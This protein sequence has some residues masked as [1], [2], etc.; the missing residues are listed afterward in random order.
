MG[1]CFSF[2]AAM[3]W[4]FRRKFRRS[5]L[6]PTTIDLGDGTVM[7]C[8]TPE[9]RDPSKPDLVL[10]HGVGGSAMWEWNSYLPL[11]TPR[12]N[13]YVPDLVFFGNS[14]TTRPERSEQFQ[15]Q[16]VAAMM[17]A[18]GVTRYVRRS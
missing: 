16:S 8:W 6:Q 4:F 7:H 3:D 9:S 11:L 13:V 10:I 12:Y 17:E 18:Q 5:G 14:Y 2:T 15:A 1:K